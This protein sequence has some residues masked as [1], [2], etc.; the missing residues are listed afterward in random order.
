MKDKLYTVTKET[1]EN[2]KVLT[3]YLNSRHKELGDEFYIVLYINKENYN[4]YLSAKR[5]QELRMEQGNFTQEVDDEGNPV[6]A[7]ID[8][9]IATI[10]KDDIENYMLIDEFNND[11]FYTYT[12]K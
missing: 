10:H 6:Y 11:N 7:Q 5:L 12:D 9:G 1:L 8:I 4:N 2:S 3:N